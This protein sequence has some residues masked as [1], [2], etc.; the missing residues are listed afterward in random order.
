MRDRQRAEEEGVKKC[1]MKRC[2]PQIGIDG[3]IRILTREVPLSLSTHSLSLS[4][5]HTHTHTHTN[6]NIHTV[7][8]SLVVY[9]TA[10]SE[11]AGTA[12][13]VVKAS[14]KPKSVGAGLV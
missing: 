2:E 8:N 3:G 14:Q 10:E 7:T 9:I 5:T 13:C 1:H 4:H 11:E 12:T 6:T